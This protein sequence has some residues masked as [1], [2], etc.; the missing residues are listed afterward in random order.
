MNAIKKF[1][2]DISKL[3]SKER[4]LLDKLILAAELMAPLYLKQK[5]SKYPG[6]NFYPH[7]ATKEEIEEAAKKDPSILDP[8]T[9]V[10]RDKSGKLITMPFCVRFKKELKKISEILKQAASLSD[11]KNFKKYLLLRAESLLNDDY[12]KSNIQFLKTG[13]SKFGFLTGPSES[14]LDKLFHK[15]RAYDN[16]VG[17]L[18]KKRTEEA[19]KFKEIILSSE[20]KI[21][22]G[23]VKIKPPKIEIRIEKTPIFSGLSADF[24]FTGSTLPNEIYLIEKY[25]LILTISEDSLKENFKKDEFPIFKTLFNKNFQKSYSEKELYKASFKCILIHEIAHNLL[26]YQGAEERLKNIFPIINELYAYI[27]GIECCGTL[28]LKDVLTSKELE[29]ILIM[30]ICRNFTWWQDFLKNP[31]VKSY[32]L[33]MVIIQ[34]FFLEKKAVEIDKKNN[35]LKV[36]FSKLYLCISEFCRVLEYYIALGTYK[37]TEEFINNYSQMKTFQKNFSPLLKK[38]SKKL[39]KE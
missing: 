24:M 17:I 13:N 39:K 29:S 30:H 8:Y 25:G 19:K 5:N 9:F 16:W 2:P 28:L 4:L 36:D 3:S 23:S 15:K 37:E 6:A 11:D 14:Y 10:E 38:I 31:D 34:N 35:F 21:L 26:Y 12:D 20:R 33:G 32:T 27:L 1:N 18:D 7:N 22:F